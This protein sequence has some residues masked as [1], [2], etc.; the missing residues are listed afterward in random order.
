MD[1]RK[2]NQIGM[3]FFLSAE[4]MFFA[5]LISAYIVLSATLESWPPVGQPRLPVLVTGVNTAILILSGV[6]VYY[7]RI[8]PAVILG[9][10]FLLVQGYEWLGLLAFGFTAAHNIYAGLFY[11]LIGTHAL[12]V[13]GGLVLLFILWLSSRKKNS[14]ASHW[15]AATLYWYFVVGVWPVLYFLVYFS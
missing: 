4:S 15:S 14:D 5:G 11:V 9:T 1:P 6:A 3:L 2:T 10:L 7:R 12:H 8:L 13:L